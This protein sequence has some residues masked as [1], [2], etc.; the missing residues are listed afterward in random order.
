M[1]AVTTPIP[2]ATRDIPVV[3]IWTL[4]KLGWFV[5]KRQSLAADLF[6]FIHGERYWLEVAEPC[7]LK[8]NGKEW[9]LPDRENILTW[10][11][12][13]EFIP[14]RF[15]TEEILRWALGVLKRIGLDRLLSVHDVRRIEILTLEQM[16][17]K[18]GFA[19]YG[20]VWQAERAILL[21]DEPFF[22]ASA[23]VSALAHEAEHLGQLDAGLFDGFSRNEWQA[24]TISQLVH[25]FMGDGIN[26][27]KDNIYLTAKEIAMKEWL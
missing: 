4:G 19:Y 27:F 9:P 15:L 16:I 14:G 13:P 25:L 24:Y 2:L 6:D 18:T 5:W 22:P 20:T 21:R 1:K 11:D 3:D 7:V 26:V 10:L 23:L 17:A 8:W 12:E